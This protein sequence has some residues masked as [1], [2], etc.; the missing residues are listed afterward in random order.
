MLTTFHSD[1]N[2]PVNRLA[3]KSVVR[4]PGIAGI[5]VCQSLAAVLSGPVALP[6]SN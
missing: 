5:A 2:C 3:S 4:V 6:A 1:G